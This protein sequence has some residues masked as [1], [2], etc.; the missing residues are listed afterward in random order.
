MRARS[1]NLVELFI[2]LK[3][4]WNTRELAESRA[5]DERTSEELAIRSELPGKQAHIGDLCYFS[6]PLDLLPVYRDRIY[7]IV[8]FLDAT[9]VSAADLVAPGQNLLATTSALLSTADVVIGDLRRDARYV[10]QDLIAALSR[11]KPPHIAVVAR[12]DQDVAADVPERHGL[13]I[14]RTLD[15]T[16]IDDNLVESFSAFFT[17]VLRDDVTRP[18][19][20]SVTLLQMGFASAA[21]IAAFRALEAALRR[22]LS[23]AVFESTIFDPKI[24]RLPVQRR[25]LAS[26]VTAGHRAGLLSTVEFERLQTWLRLRNEIVHARREISVPEA[27]SLVQDVSSLAARLGQ[28]G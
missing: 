10:R 26:L 17:E 2:E 20:E 9:A 23:D 1:D 19:N 13:R 24:S 22:R 14:L 21:V 5:K 15:E 18:Q 6:I 11:T 3:Q 4:F 27:R 8:E 12:S 7:P 25:G 28:R 16:T